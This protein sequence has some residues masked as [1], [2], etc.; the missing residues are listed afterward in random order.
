M[1]NTW[2]CV[3]LLVLSCTL[4]PGQTYQVIYTFPDSYGG[5]PSGTLAMDSAGNIY[6]TAPYGG[7]DCYISTDH[8]C[9]VVFELIAQSGGAYYTYSALHTFCEGYNQCPDGAWPFAGLV[10]DAMGNL[11]GT[12]EQGGSE[13]SGTVFELSP[14][15]VQGGSWT[16]TVL[17]SFCS[18][19]HCTDGYFPYGRLVLDSDGSLYGTTSAGGNNTN[20]RDG[21]GTVFHLTPPMPPATRWNESVIYPFCSTPMQGHCPDGDTPMI[22]LSADGLGNFYGTTKYG[23]AAHSAGDGVL[24]ELSPSAGGWTETVVRAFPEYSSP[25]G[26]L[27]LAQGNIY[28]AAQYNAGVIYETNSANGS[29]HTYKFNFNDGVDPLAGVLVSTSQDLIYGTASAA[30]NGTQGT[31]FSLGSGGQLTVL[32]WFCSQ[33]D[34]T[35]GATPAGSLIEDSTGNLYGTTLYGGS[36]GCAGNAPVN[37]CG[38]VFKFTP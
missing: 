2:L 1:K 38:V 10:I 31:L 7:T 26:E 8:G 29:L 6:G 22:G 35:D 32:H 17:H 27:T 37:G 23:G 33:F 15:S 11:Y 4:A 5:N 19:Y 18:T 9:G 12:T 3:L 28:G 20:C 30:D 14:P 16:E 25:V 21:C 34:C 13:G 36:D 24:Y